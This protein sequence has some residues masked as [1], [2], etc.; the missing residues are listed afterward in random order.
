AGAGRLAS[1][2]RPAHDGHAA[3]PSGVAARSARKEVTPA[4]SVAPA[5]PRL[6][7]AVSVAPAPPPAP[8]VAPRGAPRSLRDTDVDGA[9][10][11]D[12]RGDLTA[13][14]E[15]LALFDYFLSATG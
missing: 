11:V 1:S 10:L 12:D 5:S 6:E 4:V 2:E 3:R 8:A 15:L 9:V 7:P 13:G 14:P